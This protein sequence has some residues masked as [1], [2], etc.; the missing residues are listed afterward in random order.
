MLTFHHCCP[1]FKVVCVGL[2]ITNPVITSLFEAC[3]GVSNSASVP[4]CCL[5]YGNIIQSPTPLEFWD[6]KNSNGAK[7][8]EY[9]ECWMTFYFH[10]EF[11]HPHTHTPKQSEQ[12]HCDAGENIP[13]KFHFSAVFTTHFPTDTIRWPC[14]CVGSQFFSCGKINNTQFCEC[15]NSEH[16][17]LNLSCFLLGRGDA[18]GRVMMAFTG[19]TVAWFLG[20]TSKPISQH[21]LLIF[22]RNCQSFPSLFYVIFW[23]ALSGTQF[24]FRMF[25]AALYCVDLQE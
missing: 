25:K 23:R 20:H 7:S 17:N 8:G 22:K 2:Y 14:S 10:P 15:Q 24:M 13:P 9:G 6:T 19:T 5:K 4:R 1:P 11:T 3:H 16:A 18:G 12:V 21:L